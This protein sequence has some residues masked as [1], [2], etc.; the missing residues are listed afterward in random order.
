M[1]VTLPPSYHFPVP[2]AM[3]A[4]FVRCRR[5][6]LCCMHIRCL[7]PSL[8]CKPLAVL[9][10]LPASLVPAC[11]PARPKCLHLY[12]VGRLIGWYPAWLPTRYSDRMFEKHTVRPKS[13]LRL[14]TLSCIRRQP[15]HLHQ[16]A[17]RFR[18]SAVGF[19]FDWLHVGILN[20]F[21]GLCC[22][23]RPPLLLL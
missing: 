7:F 21:C 20:H 12:Y 18:N 14:I 1:W 4:L 13:V 10:Q 16:K 22:T 3:P 9:W 19:P 5:A 17:P 11:L 8:L 23:T 15:H 2:N 6:A